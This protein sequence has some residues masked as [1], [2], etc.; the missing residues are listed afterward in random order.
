MKKSL[1]VLALSMIASQAS[2]YMLI[3]KNLSNYALEAKI[4]YAGKGVCGDK[5]AYIKPKETY[6]RQTDGCCLNLLT[7]TTVD[8]SGKGKA[9]K[10]GQKASVE[11]RNTGF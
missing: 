1:L 5:I 7:V 10:L 4:E 2:A 6:T 9:A 8:K 11:G 3:V